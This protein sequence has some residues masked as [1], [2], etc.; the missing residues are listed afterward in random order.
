MDGGTGGV[1]GSDEGRVVIESDGR[2]CA[3]LDE[4]TEGVAAGDVGAVDSSLATSFFLHASK[5]TCVTL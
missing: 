1:E 3:L 5:S 4:L 2:G